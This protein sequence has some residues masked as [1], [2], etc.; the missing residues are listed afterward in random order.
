MKETISRDKQSHKEKCIL[1]ILKKKNKIKE[2]KSWRKDPNFYRIIPALT[3]QNIKP[4][5]SKEFT[6]KILSKIK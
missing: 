6:I 4:Q 3:R 5:I 1:L 2:G